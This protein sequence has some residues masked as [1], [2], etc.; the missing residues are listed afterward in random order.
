MT[1]ARGSTILGSI[2][3]HPHPHVAGSGFHLCELWGGRSPILDAAVICIL[4]FTRPGVDWFAV[5]D[6]EVAAWW[7]ADLQRWL[8]CSLCVMFCS[9]LSHRNLR[10]WPAMNNRWGSAVHVFLNWSTQGIFIQD[11]LHFRFEYFLFLFKN[12]W[13]LWE[14]KIE[15]AKL[16][17]NLFV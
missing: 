2:H 4:K 10:I 15:K 3:S 17:T 1:Y 6:A 13:N 8:N 5:D 9:I 12:I 16:W 14:T 11:R 7:P